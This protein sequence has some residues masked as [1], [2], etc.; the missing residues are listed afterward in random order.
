LTGNEI[1]TDGSDVIELPA[2]SGVLSSMAAATSAAAFV[3]A[4]TVAPDNEVT[5]SSEIKLKK[6]HHF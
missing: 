3:A 4:L 5:R 2:G 1:A 6:D